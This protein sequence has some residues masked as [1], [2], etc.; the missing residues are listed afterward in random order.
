MHVHMRM[1]ML[2]FMSYLRRT[3]RAHARGHVRVA[4]CMRTMIHLRRRVVADGGT[5]LSLH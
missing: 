1:R 3:V 5:A 2:I 4:M